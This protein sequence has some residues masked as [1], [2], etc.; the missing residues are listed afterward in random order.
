MN[1]L[2]EIKPFFYGLMIYLQI[3]KEVAVILISLIF[4]DMFA[5]SIKAVV[6]PE[7]KFSFGTFWAGFIKKAFLLLIVMVLA[8]MARGLGYDDFKILPLSL[9]Y[10]KF[11]PNIWMLTG[12]Y[13]YFIF[14]L[15]SIYIQFFDQL[16]INM[17]SP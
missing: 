8:L 5:G 14:N 15:Y 3:D 1:K 17:K 10:P 11:S 13:K 9:K 12:L 2:N 6:V 7:L 16:K 4:I